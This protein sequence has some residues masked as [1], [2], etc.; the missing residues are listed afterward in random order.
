MFSIQLGGAIGHPGLGV[1]WTGPD[2]D[3]SRHCSGPDTTAA[4]LAPVVVA[5]SAPEASPASS[6]S[7]AAPGPLSSLSSSAIPR[8]RRRRRPRCR[9][10]RPCRPRCR[11]RRLRRRRARRRKIPRTNPVEDVHARHVKVH[12]RIVGQIFLLDQCV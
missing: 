8:C 1:R 7:L 12:K 2:M 6:S 11:R 10:Q 4:F 9:R 5:E 3:K